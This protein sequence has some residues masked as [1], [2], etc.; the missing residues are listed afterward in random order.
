V[1]NHW[2]E[3]LLCLIFIRHSTF[4]RFFL[5]SAVQHSTTSQPHHAEHPYLDL[6]TTQYQTDM[7][8]IK[9]ADEAASP[10][11]DEEIAPSSVAVD[12]DDNSAGEGTNGNCTNVDDDGNASA[13]N[14][15]QVN[16]ADTAP[17][18]N[19]AT[20]SS[21]EEEF[22]SPRRLILE[23]KSSDEKLHV[24]TKKVQSRHKWIEET[25]L[26]D[27]K[28]SGDEISATKD[29][30]RIISSRASIGGSASAVNAAS[31]ET[32][33]SRNVLPVTTKSTT[34]PTSIDTS[35]PKGSTLSERIALARLQKQTSPVSPSSPRSNDTALA[36]ARTAIEGRR[37]SREAAKARASA[38]LEEIVGSHEKSGGNDDEVIDVGGGGV[39]GR[40]SEEGEKD[41]GD[42]SNAVGTST[43][44]ES[45]P[46]QD[47]VMS[48]EVNPSIGDDETAPINNADQGNGTKD[49]ITE[50]NTS[51]EEDTATK[52][53]TITAPV[54]ED[55][56]DQPNQISAI[57][58]TG[59]L[60]AD[61]GSLSPEAISAVSQAALESLAGPPKPKK[62]VAKRAMSTFDPLLETKPTIESH[63]SHSGDDSF[64][65][66]VSYSTSGDT[67]DLQQAETN[68]T[69]GAL[70]KI[71]YHGERKPINKGRDYDVQEGFS[72]DDS[73]TSSYSYNDY[74]D[75]E[76][77]ASDL[78][79]GP[80][81]QKALEEA[82]AA[83]EAHTNPPTASSHK[84]NMSYRLN[85]SKMNGR[86]SISAIPPGVPRSLY[87]Q[88]RSEV[89][90][91]GSGVDMEVTSSDA[92]GASEWKGFNHERM[93]RI[94]ECCGM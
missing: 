20:T 3:T 32:K 79:H 26:N 12:A 47:N 17:N 64:D 46:E 16:T 66:P 42:C 76:S 7:S 58:D 88:S 45:N 23:A 85:G 60:A 86:K 55:L 40:K 63:P 67:V 59:T 62:E 69:M 11:V 65:E 75:S 94:G 70:D 49:V 24:S 83:R 91:V 19:D 1:T 14:N 22:V 82:R 50:V 52:E 71:M 72:Y 29:Y 43:S 5:L 74:N 21:E 48:G 39:S 93:R 30:N 28:Q 34:K 15:L 41:V 38:A 73:V 54:E 18:D 68:D 25:L 51:A 31:D 90:Q 84:A 35:T 44:G 78:S 13:T 33:T 77:Q 87:N 61:D 6:D 10:P 92:V 80:L 36:R 57:E 89:E 56:S 4:S 9:Q 8:L 2:T 53:E 37:K 27:N 81:W